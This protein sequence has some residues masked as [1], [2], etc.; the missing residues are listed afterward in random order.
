MDL[1]EQIRLINDAY[2]EGR[3][4]ERE[5]WLPVLE[6]LKCSVAA[7]DGDHID[8]IESDY[9]FATAQ[10]VAMARAAIAS[11]EGKS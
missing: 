1:Q 5:E 3:K 10:R 11:V 4:D 7:F 9:G 2:A 6:A 8:E